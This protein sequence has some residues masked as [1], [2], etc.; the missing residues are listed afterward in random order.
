MTVEIEKESSTEIIV[1]VNGKKIYFDL[2]GSKADL[3]PIFD[4]VKWYEES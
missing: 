4:D 3:K 1:N 2:K